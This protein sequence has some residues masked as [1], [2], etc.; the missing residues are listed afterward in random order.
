M[1]VLTFSFNAIA[2]L[3]LVVALGTFLFRIAL[4]DARFV[5]SA[6]RFCFNVA[7]PI[8]LFGSIVSIDLKKLFNPSLYAFI[9]ITIVVVVG[10]LMLIVPRL[11]P[12]NQ[13]RGALVQ[14]IYRGNFL[15]MG[16]PLAISL[17]GQEG[18]APTAMLLPI[19]VGVFNLIA[20]FVLEY[21]DDNRQTRLN[22]GRVLLSVLK[23]PLII[24]SLA[25]AVFSLLGIR[26]PVFLDRAVA[27]VGK[28][29]FPLALILLGAQ[30]SWKKTAANVKML[31]TAVAVRMILIPAITV[32][33]A[34]MIGF[35]GPELGA[36]FILF[37]APTAVSS[38]I[39]ARSM[40]S[41]ADLAGQIVLFTTI[42]SAFTIFG[43]VSLM[44]ALQLF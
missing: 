20:V 40:N 30:F 2:P 33:A 18:I 36:I 24:G 23:N 26:L 5:D 6:N 10:L 43:G 41:D 42:V 25:G 34:I 21:F 1:E 29:A 27:D 4:I 15:L 7:F 31:I 13:Q 19:V 37:S 16:Y 39:M 14:G 22:K 38:S 28:I 17:F 11:V 3:I 32:T 8:S 35:R 12:G 9:L 44:R